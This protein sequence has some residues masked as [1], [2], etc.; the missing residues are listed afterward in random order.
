[1]LNE[2]SKINIHDQLSE[3]L[4][5]ALNTRLLIEDVTDK[6]A[7]YKNLPAIDKYKTIYNESDYIEEKKKYERYYRTLVRQY[8][9]LLKKLV[10]MPPI[11]LATGEIINDA[12]VVLVEEVK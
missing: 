4:G 5:K 9:R 3:I 8:D 11:L 12:Q 10:E 2:Q 1:M 6:I 7:N